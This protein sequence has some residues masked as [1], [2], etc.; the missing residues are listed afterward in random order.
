MKISVYSI[1]DVLFAG[2]AE[3]LICRTPLGEIT[4]LDNHLP[5]VSTVTGPTVE[6]IDKNNKKNIIKIVSGFLEVKPES[7][8]VILANVGI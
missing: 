8:A 4:V 2:E 7:E 5:L 1:Q 3:K 6:I